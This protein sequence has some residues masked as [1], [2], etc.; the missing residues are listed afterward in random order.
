MRV[1]QVLPTISFGDAVGN[2][3]IAI[4]KILKNNGYKT[5][6]Y[7]ENI[8]KRLP[9]GTAKSINAIKKI[10]KEDVI[11]YHLSMG[12]GLNEWIKSVDCRKICI[13]H[14]IT[15]PAFFER[16]NTSLYRLCKTG[17]REVEGLK[18]E[19]DFVW[20]DSEF[21]KQN[22]LEM[23]YR[24][25]IS[26]L[27]ILIPFEDYRVSSDQHVLSQ[28][29]DNYTNILFV[30]RVAPN[31]KYQD[32]ISVFNY[33][34]KLYNPN[35][36]LILVGS[37][38]GTENYYERLNEYVDKLD[39]N[40]VIFTG[41]IKFKEI[42]SYYK[43]AD[44]FLCMSE[45]EG[46]CVPLVEAML[47]DLPIIAYDSCAIKDTLGGS[48]VLVK[49]KNFIEVAGLLNRLVSDLKLREDIIHNQRERLRDFDSTIIQEQFLTELQE[50]INNKRANSK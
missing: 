33:Y 23:G 20:A 35:S 19:F 25:P 48:G 34:Q 44:A 45:H 43:L 12:T 5:D 46:F 14:N 32:I 39:I 17:L 3:T 10:E 30:G 11:I 9:G 47:F 24:C 27:P 42:I 7:A 37:Y 22:L 41:K 40:N 28:Y 26:V 4:E 38:E 15:P 18:D 50:F 8:D 49:E 31:K 2:D 6:I 1:I 13:Y 16:Y 36:R 21:N 29:N